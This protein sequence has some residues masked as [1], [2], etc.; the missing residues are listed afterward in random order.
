[1]AAGSGETIGVAVAG[2]PGVAG[3]RATSGLTVAGP[4]AASARSI[5]TSGLIA[6]AVL[7][8]SVLPPWYIAAISKPVPDMMIRPSGLR[9]IVAYSLS[10]LVVR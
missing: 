6:L 9:F 2:V 10:L 7:W 5:S 4:S 3:G 1:M 8:V